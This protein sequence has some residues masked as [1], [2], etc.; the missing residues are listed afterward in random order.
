MQRTRRIY[1][2]CARGHE[3]KP[4]T[5]SPVR[6]KGVDTGRVRCL[7]CVAEDYRR[8]KAQKSEK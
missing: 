5:T 1:T 3:Y 6:I 4:G 7:V 2:Q 8:R